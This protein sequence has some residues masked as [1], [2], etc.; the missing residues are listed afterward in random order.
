MSE[1]EKREL[2]DAALDEQLPRFDEALERLGH[3]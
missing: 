3:S 1:Q 2:I